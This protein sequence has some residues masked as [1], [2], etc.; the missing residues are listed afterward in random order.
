MNI[1][2]EPINLIVDIDG[3]LCPIKKPDENYEDLIPYQ[4]IINKLRK[5]NNPYNCP[6]G[7][8][9]IIHFTIY[10]IEKM[11]KRSV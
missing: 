9:T 10:E 3:T 6:H 1:N 5:C 7:R 8:P 11:F 2:D 4:E